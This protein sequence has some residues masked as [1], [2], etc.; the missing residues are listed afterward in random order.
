VKPSS[1]GARCCGLAHP[2]IDR[3]IASSTLRAITHRKSSGGVDAALLTVFG[4]D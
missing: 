1:V 3:V 4:V 2:G